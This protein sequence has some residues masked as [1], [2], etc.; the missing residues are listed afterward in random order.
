MF[1]ASPAEPEGDGEEADA[2]DGV[3]DPV[4]PVADD[5]PDEQAETVTSPDTDRTTRPAR[6]ARAR[7]LDVDKGDPPQ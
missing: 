4:V 3:P 6:T 2:D 7:T 1:I 5:G